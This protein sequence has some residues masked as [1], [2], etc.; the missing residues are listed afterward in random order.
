MFKRLITPLLLLGLLRFTPAIA[1]TTFTDGFVREFQVTKR[2]TTSEADQMESEVL[3]DKALPNIWDTKNFIKPEIILGYLAGWRNGNNDSVFIKIPVNMQTNTTGVLT[4]GYNAGFELFINGKLIKSDAPQKPHFFERDA[5]KTK[6]QLNKGNNLIVL[7]LNNVKS[8]YSLAFRVALTPKQIYSTENWFQPESR[9]EF[10]ATEKV[11]PNQR[12]NNNS[13]LYFCKPPFVKRM[14]DHKIRHAIMGTPFRE[15]HGRYSR[16]F[17]NSGMPAP[18]ILEIR[19]PLYSLYDIRNLKP[20]NYIEMGLDKAIDSSVPEIELSP[21]GSR[22]QHSDTNLEVALDVPTFYDKW[23]N[24]NPPERM[25]DYEGVP[26]KHEAWDGGD[27]N[28]SCYSFHDPR[29]REF[30]IKTTASIAKMIN[31]RNDKKVGGLHV[32]FP[33]NNDWYYPIRDKFYDYSSSAV[34]A[35]QKFLEKKYISIDKL[36]MKYAT[37]HTTFS[38][39]NAPKPKIGEMD[40]SQAWQDWQ[41][42]RTDTVYQINRDIFSE[43][44]KFE[45]NRE[46]V[47]WMTTSLRASSRDGIVLDDAMLLEKEFPNTLMTLTC[48]DFM[49]NGLPLSG[50]LWGQLALAYNLPIAIEPLHN[51]PDSYQKT[52][53][54]I[55]RFPVKKVNWLYFIHLNP[56]ATPWIIWVMNQRGLAD[57]LADAQLLQES[58]VNLFSYSDVRLQTPK[59]LTGDKFVKGQ[60]DLY[61]ALQSHSISL[62]MITD[63]SLSIDLKKYQNVLLADT[64]LL[65]PK[66]ISKIV[67]FVKDGGK[68]IILGNSGQ[69]NLDTGKADYP[70]LTALGVHTEAVRRTDDGIRLAS[71]PENGVVVK[72]SGSLIEIASW[73]VGTGKVVFHGKGITSLL[74][75][76]GFFNT[77]AV[78]WLESQGIK[79]SVKFEYDGLASSFVKTKGNVR[80]IGIINISG[81]GYTTKVQ[82]LPAATISSLEGVELVSGEKVQIKNG[83]FEINF[84]FPWQIK[85][86]KL[87]LK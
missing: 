11:A 69:Y 74:N 53:Y 2:M 21:I 10:S 60:F 29:H 86:V 26:V 72:S 6:A 46:L 82:F 77:D 81:G 66:M 33:A 62:P 36:N 58:T 4:I 55:L 7:R 75:K 61:N 28:I 17:N 39:V 14:S 71:I 42:F 47:A 54:N 78:S 63:Y 50:E 64:K 80:Y 57:E 67:E 45:P 48:F 41:A 27:V 79:P 34:K 68:A 32:R 84:D 9:T 20:S 25:L 15:Y 37:E 5:F 1:E 22:S 13:F 31:Q 51:A 52:F 18:D 83:V 49:G 19:T 23:F 8:H 87:E 12:L 56:A 3:V 16:Y 76:D 43:L 59:R 38:N 73:P 70:L 40:I 85:V 30:V 65:R 44:R 35:F 24:G